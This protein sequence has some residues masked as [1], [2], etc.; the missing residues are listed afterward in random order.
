[1][2]WDPQVSDEAQLALRLRSPRRLHLPVLSRHSLHPRA[3]G[4]SYATR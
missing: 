1:M 4:V 2:V 3:S